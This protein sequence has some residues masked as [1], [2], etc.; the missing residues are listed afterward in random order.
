MNALLNSMNIVRWSILSFLEAP[1]TPNLQN[2][3]LQ[4]LSELSM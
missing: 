4:K 2:V 3:I 1:Q